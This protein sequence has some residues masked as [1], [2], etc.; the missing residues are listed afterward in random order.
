MVVPPMGPRVLSLLFLGWETL[1][2][3]SLGER[4][5]PSDQK[6]C[7][8]P[9]C[10]SSLSIYLIFHLYHCLFRVAFHY[11][12]DYKHVLFFFL[13][14]QSSRSPI[15]WRIEKARMRFWLWL[16]PA[17]FA[18]CGCEIV[19]LEEVQSLLQLF[20]FTKYDYDVRNIT[21]SV[22]ISVSGASAHIHTNTH[23]QE[24]LNRQVSPTHESMVC[25]LSNLKCRNL[26][27]EDHR[28]GHCQ[29]SISV[30]VIVSSLL[31]TELIFF[32]YQLKVSVKR[33][34]RE[35]NI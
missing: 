27:R 32:E 7:I 17:S 11:F 12:L 26:D 19:S 15:A 10:L 22:D 30:R 1:L 4:P 31:N 9:C 3:C 24:C 34:H 21:I 5:G 20:W 33:F 14:Q 18:P 8:H 23:T 25:H 35:A 6:V 29:I 13:T 16:M 2:C 28:L